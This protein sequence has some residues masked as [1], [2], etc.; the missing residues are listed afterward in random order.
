MIRLGVGILITIIFVIIVVILMIIVTIA[1]TVTTMM[2]IMMNITATMIILILIA[3]IV[4]VTSTISICYASWDGTR[5]PERERLC[6]LYH[7]LDLV[8]LVVLLVFII[9]ITSV[10]QVHISLARH[11]LGASKRFNVGTKWFTISAWHK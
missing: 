10:F 9:S 4:A 1:M 6:F 8:G 5:Y 11:L 7:C 2:N 3:V